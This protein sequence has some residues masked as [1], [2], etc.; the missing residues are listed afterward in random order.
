MT[1]IIPVQQVGEREPL[2]DAEIAALEL[3]LARAKTSLILEHPFI[4]TVAMNMPFE[5]TNEV[6][7]AATNGKKVMFNPEFCNL[8]TD[9]E[10]KFLVAH[11]CMHP[12]LEHNYRRFER[13]HKRWNQAA[14]YVINKLLID[15][16][17][18]RMPDVGLYSEGIYADGGGTS[19]GIYNILPEEEGDGDGYGGSGMDE[20][21]DAEGTPQEV[22]QQQAEMKVQVA[23]AAQAARM[24][25]KMSAGMEKIV[26]EILNP[27]VDWRDVL[28]RFVE[29][30]KDD[31]RT[32]SRPSRRFIQQGLYLPS[33][34]GEAMG[35]IV[36]G[37]DCSGSCIDDIPQFTNEVRT[38][39]E[40][41]K[42]R[43]LH[44]VYFDST[45]SHVDCFT[46]DD[47]FHMEGHGGGG[48]AFS[49]VFRKI[50]ELDVEPVCTVILTDLCCG[51]FGPQP[52]YPVLW[53]S[54]HS[55]QAEW[56]EVVM[57]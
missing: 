55:D 32:W 20:C 52:E 25:G 48:T 23:Q 16:S 31:Q 41:Q 38:V 10:L 1:N 11:E 44:V 56:G 47:D 13:T 34:S 50:E 33:Q 54:N 42:P 27:K 30:C 26:D 45:V 37:V 35:P 5:I 8:L 49:P 29:K 6:P 51:D 28:Q 3:K 12:M 39:F 2:T 18:G 21:L 57:M 22:E 43:E 17:I 53:V 40:D 19:D 36:F 9:E 24:C 7:T 4:G 15:D 14:D 46:K